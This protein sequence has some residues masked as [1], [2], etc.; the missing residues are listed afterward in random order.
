MYYNH[1]LRSNLQE[2]RNQLYKSEYHDFLNNFKFFFNRIYGERILKS[3]IENIQSEYPLNNDELSEWMKQLSQNK[4]NYVNEK[5]RFSYY[6]Y[7]CNYFLKENKN[8]IDYTYLGFKDRSE[9]LLNRVIT[10]LVNYL[11]STLDDINTLLYILEKYKLRTEWFTKDILKDKYKNALNRQYEQV[12][13]DDIR[14]YLFD[15]GIDYPFST[16][17]S[18]SGR[19]DVVSLVNT[20]DPLVMEI[21]IYDSERKYGKER[22]I[23]GFT[24]IVK[25]AN[26]YHKNIGYLV[27]FNLDEIEIEVES[28]E[29]DNKFPNRVIFNGKTYYIIIINLNYDTSASKQGK[30]NRLTIPYNDLTS[31]KE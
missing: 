28:I 12:L 17:K 14:Q 18:A 9:A 2:W 26:D 4:V 8:P 16:P 30:L 23:S 20:E 13:E 15:Q 29:S 22:I 19:A 6:V 31:L 7:Y 21:K 25:Y 24:Q 3:I 11:H 5:Q 10:P 1:Q 27:V